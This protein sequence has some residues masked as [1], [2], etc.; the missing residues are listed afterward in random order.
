MSDPIYIPPEFMEIETECFECP[1]AGV[2]D[3]VIKHMTEKHSYSTKQSRSWLYN[4]M[5]SFDTDSYGHPL[6]NNDC[7]EHGAIPLGETCGGCDAVDEEIERS[8]ERLRVYR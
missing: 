1:F 4:W 2:P 8:K 3:A 7:R 6:S 5:E